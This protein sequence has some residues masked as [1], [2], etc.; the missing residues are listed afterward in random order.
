[1]HTYSME[2]LSEE[3]RSA[4]VE[5]F[6]HYILNSFSAYFEQELPPQF[7]DRLLQM[8]K[9][10]PSVAV[11][12]DSGMLVG[13]GLLHAYH[14]AP[15][16]R[17]TAE[18]SYFLAPAHTGRGLGKLV[19]ERLCEGARGMEIKSIVA[20]VS[21]RNGESISFH[22]KNG[23]RQVGRLESVGRKFDT[24]F[25]VLWFQKDLSP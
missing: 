14:P 9:G 22:L 24:E 12:D 23:F 16:F 4:V 18:A 10:Y 25:D 8:A 2:P 3:H 11:R 21:S 15:T 7:F 19:L 1:M 13:F 5:L 17:Q 20:S 6:N